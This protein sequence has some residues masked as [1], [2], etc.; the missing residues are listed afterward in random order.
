MEVYED[1][2][3]FHEAVL[4]TTGQTKLNATLIEKDYFCTVLLQS[5]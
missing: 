2:A 4:F 3:F 1:Q 5:T